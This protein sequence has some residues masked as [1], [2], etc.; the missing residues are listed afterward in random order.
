MSFCQNNTE[1]SKL[2]MP[3][4][5]RMVLYQTDIQLVTHGIISI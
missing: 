4:S 1:I 3:N 2:I 5:A